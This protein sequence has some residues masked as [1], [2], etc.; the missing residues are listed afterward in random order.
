MKDVGYTRRKAG[1]NGRHSEE[2]GQG[3]VRGGLEAEEHDR[4]PFSGS[5][6]RPS[7]WRR[8]GVLLTAASREEVA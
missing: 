1:T 5:E 4:G 7:P 8:D 6:A 2:S 3:Q